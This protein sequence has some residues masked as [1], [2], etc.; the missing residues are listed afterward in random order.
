MQFRL[1]NSQPIKVI[2]RTSLSFSREDLV[3][4]ARLVQAGQVLL[5]DEPRSPVI[6]RLKAA[7][8]RLGLPVPNGL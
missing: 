5:A 6:A 7:M 8:T 1:R 3:A 4:L 2:E